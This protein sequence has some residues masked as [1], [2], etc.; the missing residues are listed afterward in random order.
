[1]AN[2]K[3]ISI[4]CGLIV[5]L[6]FSACRSVDRGSFGSFKRS[7]ST[8]SH[9]YAVIE[10]PTGSA[11]TKLVERFEVRPG[12]CGSGSTYNDCNNDRERSELSEE[13]KSRTLGTTNWYG[14]SLFVPEDHVNIYPTK[15]AFGQ[16][17]QK[18]ARPA[19]LFQNSSG[20]YHADDNLYGSNYKL[21]DEKDLRGKWHRIEVHAKWSKIDDGFFKVWVNGEQKVDFS[22]R[23]MTATAMYFKYG[24]YRSFISRYAVSNGY[25]YYAKTPVELPVQVVYFANVQRANS[26]VGLTAPE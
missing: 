7:L 15:V 11:P 4:A 2:C 6:G 23:T 20:G 16:F 14:W 26:R 24:L 19:W 8:T 9:G 13:D 22:G 5:V 12:D 3:A 25:P 18:G 10:D 1:M 17:H 21:V